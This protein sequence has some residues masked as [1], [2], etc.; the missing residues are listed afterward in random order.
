MDAN[1][2][3]SG[4]CEDF[5]PLLNASFV[6]VVGD[7]P[8]FYAGTS[9]SRITLSSSVAVLLMTTLIGGLGNA[10]V[11][12]LVCA[13]KKLRIPPNIQLV[14]LA[15]VDLLVCIIAAPVRVHTTLKALTGSYDICSSLTR[16]LCYTQLFLVNG[17][18]AAS[19]VSLITISFTRAVVIGSGQSTKQLQWRLVTACIVVS[20]V[21]GVGFGT[22]IASRGVSRNC[23]SF[24]A[25]E[26]A[27]DENLEAFLPVLILVGFVIIAISYFRIYLVTKRTTAAVHAHSGQV[28]GGSTD[29]GL[30]KN[31][32]T[33]RICV[34]I[35]V[36]FFVLY[37]PFPI[38]FILNIFTNNRFNGRNPFQVHF[39]HSVG[40]FGSAV[41]PIVYSLRSKV[42]RQALRHALYNEPSSTVVPLDVPSPTARSTTRQS[43]VTTERDAI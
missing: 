17:S 7:T 21:S 29:N 28:N 34:T 11:I 22:Y 36:L 24:F 10:T 43:R 30:K 35:V 25:R 42:M 6:V 15:T 33:T 37:M 9:V 12:A 2:T 3:L 16:A 13:T 1:L 26:G 18:I 23:L 40:L 14:C 27:T 38:A 41:N 31:I 5:E 19:L 39:W 4:D 20:S 32:A 8:M